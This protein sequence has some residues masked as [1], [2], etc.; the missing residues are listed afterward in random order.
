MKIIEVDII[1]KDQALIRLEDG[2]EIELTIGDG[3]TRSLMVIV[4][5][6]P[7]ED[8]TISQIKGRGRHQ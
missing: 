5:G 3:E 2:S 4:Q 8:V 1:S 6:E 7:F